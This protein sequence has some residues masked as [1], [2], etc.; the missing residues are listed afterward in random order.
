M[1][2]AQPIEDTQ[3]ASIGRANESASDVLILRVAV[4]TSRIF[5][6]S[7]KNRVSAL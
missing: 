4:F 1:A 6:S 3:S 2:K 5:E 7:S